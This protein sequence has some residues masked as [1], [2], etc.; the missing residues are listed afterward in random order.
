[1]VKLGKRRHGVLLVHGERFRGEGGE[2]VQPGRVVHGMVGALQ[3]RYVILLRVGH[4]LEVIRPGDVES[5]LGL[6]GGLFLLGAPAK[7]K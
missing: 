6:R 2:V 4:M 7:S 1:L 3:I 5:A